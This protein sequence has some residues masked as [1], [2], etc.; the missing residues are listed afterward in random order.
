MVGTAVDI[1]LPWADL[2]VHALGRERADQ[3]GYQASGQGQRAIAVNSGRELAAGPGLEVGGSQ[4]CTLAI[5][6]DE[7]V[8]EDGQRGTRGHTAAR[9][10]ETSVKRILEGLDLHLGLLS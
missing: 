7:N 4:D 2:E 6:P 3:V 1:G 8:G 10:F 5:G 9:G